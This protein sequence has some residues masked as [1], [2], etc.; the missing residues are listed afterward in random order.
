MKS[1]RPNIEDPVAQSSPSPI[2]WCHLSSQRHLSTCSVWWPTLVSSG[3]TPVFVLR[4]FCLAYFF[5]QKPKIKHPIRYKLISR[6]IRNHERL[7]SFFLNYLNPTVLI[8]QHIPA[9]KEKLERAAI[10]YSPQRARIGLAVCIITL[11]VFYCIFL[12]KYTVI[13]LKLLERPCWTIIFYQFIICVFFIALIQV[14]QTI[15]WILYGHASKFCLFLSWR[16]LPKVLKYTLFRISSKNEK[17]FQTPV[18][19]GIL[20]VCCQSSRA[21]TDH[22]S[23]LSADWLPY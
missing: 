5:Y 7:D 14:Q 2:F 8:L 12:I 23:P 15:K 16:V 18:Y 20:V 17:L 10:Q 4:A 19:F 3:S 13:G 21:T 11:K 22:R 9:N 1:F 6:A